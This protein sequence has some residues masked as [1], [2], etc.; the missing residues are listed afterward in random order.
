MLIFIAIVVLFLIA[1]FLPIW[2]IKWKYIDSNKSTMVPRPVTW[3]CK[4]AKE[5]AKGIDIK[6]CPICG[7]K[8][9][10]YLGTHQ[11]L[12]TSWMVSDDNNLMLWMLLFG[13]VDG[14]KSIQNY[15][16]VY[17]LGSNVKYKIG[18]FG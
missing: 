2:C 15:S 11:N 17:S 6:N 13:K 14:L 12:P 8:I 4:H 10:K 5:Y 18:I 9:K 16:H 7:I 1:S 3:S